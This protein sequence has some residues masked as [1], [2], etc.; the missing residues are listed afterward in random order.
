[1]GN[2]TSIV[3]LESVVVKD[4]LTYEEVV[5]DILD[6]EVQSCKTNKSLQLKFCG[7]VSLLSELL[8]KKKQI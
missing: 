6:C 4:S 7:G 5:V 1:M 3:P 8:G 2:P